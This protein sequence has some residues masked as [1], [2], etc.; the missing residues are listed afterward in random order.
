MSL[1]YIPSPLAHAVTLPT[2]LCLAGGTEGKNRS[3]P[4]S[5]DSPPLETVPRMGIILSLAST[6]VISPLSLLKARRL[7]QSGKMM[8]C[9]QGGGGTIWPVTTRRRAF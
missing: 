6:W 8:G 5:C 1:P 3:P 7:S 4:S 9:R 2:S